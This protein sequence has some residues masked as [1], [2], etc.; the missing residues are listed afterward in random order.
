MKSALDSKIL[1]TL[2]SN[3]QAQHQTLVALCT[4]QEQHFQSLLQAQAADWQ[5]S[6]SLVQ[7]VGITAATP[8][9]AAAKPHIVLL[10]LGPQDDPQSFVAIA[11]PVGGSQ[12]H[13]STAP[14]HQPA[15]VPGSEVGYN[16]TSRPHSRT[17]LVFQ[18]PDIQ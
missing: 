2:I 14:S 13:S 16:A 4:E 5:A 7:L 17:T 1:Q 18:C 10:K 15:V 11:T 3:Y 9:D 8:A 12:V 6:Q